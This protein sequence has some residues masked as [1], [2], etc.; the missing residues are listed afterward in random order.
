[1]SRLAACS[2]SYSHTSDYM[3]EYTCVLAQCMQ[4]VEH[5]IVRSYVLHAVGRNI[6][7][8]YIHYTCCMKAIVHFMHTPYN[9]LLLVWCILQFMIIAHMHAK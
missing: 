6:L 9:P 3:S 2:C 4:Y 7:C 8:T 5:I 1:M